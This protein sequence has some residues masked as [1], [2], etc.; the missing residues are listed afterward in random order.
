MTSL[1]SLTSLPDAHQRALAWFSDSTG[2]EI[3]W[4]DP[5]PDG[6]YLLN[7][8][9]GIH[10]PKG[11]QYA[12]SVRQAINSPYADREIVFD[13]S[14]NWYFDYFQEGEDLNEWHKEFTNR[15][16]MANMADGVP[17]GV[18]RQIKVKPKPRYHIMGLAQV[19]DWKDG[20]FRL[21]GFQTLQEA[22]DKAV[23]EL[24]LSDARRRVSASLVVREGAG[25]FRATALAAFQGQCAISSCK[26]VPVLE[27]AHI[28]PY[29]GPHTNG[30]GNSLLLRSDLHTL[31]DKG[32]LAI[33]PD[34]LRVKIHP[35]LRSTEYGDFEGSVIK[36]PKSDKSFWKGAFKL[37]TE[38][39]SNTEF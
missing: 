22:T 21:Q 24:S 1:A 8:A 27:A 20:Y 17:V 38:L 33:D 14:G 26:V 5:L 39:S 10:K 19:V 3:D 34:D 4:P 23:F 31:F 2:Q 12:L 30:V 29:L 18:V 15:A 36:L 11:W 6:L 35:E 28:V 9:K 16:L 7:K 32:Y 37:R 13:D 25:L